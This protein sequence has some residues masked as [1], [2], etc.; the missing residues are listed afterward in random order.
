MTLVI[1]VSFTVQGGASPLYVASLGGHTDVVDILVKAGADVNQTETVVCLF[2]LA[3]H[4][5]Q[6]FQKE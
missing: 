2:D 6:I 1:V 5:T 4:D 3:V